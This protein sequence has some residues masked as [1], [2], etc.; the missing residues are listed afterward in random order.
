MRCGAAREVRRRTGVRELLAAAHAGVAAVRAAPPV[1]PQPAAAGRGSSGVAREHDQPARHGA[2]AR[3]ARACRS[4]R[5]TR[6]AATSP[7]STTG[8]PP[9]EAASIAGRSRVS[10]GEVSA[11]APTP[12]AISSG[13]RAAAASSSSGHSS[14]WIAEAPRCRRSAWPN[15]RARTLPGDDDRRHRA[16]A[17]GGAGLRDR[18]L[19]ADQRDLPAGCAAQRVEHALRRGE[20]EEL[21]A[22]TAQ[23]GRA[24]P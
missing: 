13:T 8:S 4:V 17:A 20:H 12:A 16:A 15:V 6:A 18:G 2:A 22:V 3:A 1:S 14:R 9:P 23:L 7:A 5:C 11:S 24:G 10:A 19:E 21:G